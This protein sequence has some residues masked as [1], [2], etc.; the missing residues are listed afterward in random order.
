M[1]VP[2]HLPDGRVTAIN[3]VQIADPAQ[4]QRRQLAGPARHGKLGEGCQLLAVR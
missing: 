4:T 3:E 1:T 2:V